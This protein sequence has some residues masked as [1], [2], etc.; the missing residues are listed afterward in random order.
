MRPTLFLCKIPFFISFINSVCVSYYFCAWHPWFSLLVS[1]C[2]IPLIVTVCVLYYFCA[3]SPLS[4]LLNS[5][6]FYIISVHGI[7]LFSTLTSSCVFL[8]LC[9]TTLIFTFLN[10]MYVLY[11]FYPWQLSY[12]PFLTLYIYIISLHGLSLTSP[13]YSTRFYII[14]VCVSFLISQF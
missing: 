13:S 11:H 5:V 8:F 12:F 3:Y 14:S 7:H 10:S 4:S 6:C 1:V 2:L 9:M